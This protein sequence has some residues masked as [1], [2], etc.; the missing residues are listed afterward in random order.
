MNTP[1]PQIVSSIVNV[2]PMVLM[3]QPPQTSC[4]V[5]SAPA[6]SPVPCTQGSQSGTAVQA[7]EREWVRDKLGRL[8]TRSQIDH[9]FQHHRSEGIW[10]KQ[11]STH[12]KW[13]KPEDARMQ[14]VSHQNVLEKDCNIP[15]ALAAKDF[16]ELEGI[17]DVPGKNP[18][19]ALSSY[20]YDTMPWSTYMAL[21]ELYTYCVLGD[22]V[23]AV[24]NLELSD[25]SLGKL[26]CIRCWCKKYGLRSRLER[27]PL[28]QKFFL[29]MHK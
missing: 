18:M 16:T 7:A 12:G 15:D 6:M 3:K 17:T 21:A 1:S 13:Q 10:L 29:S 23:N 9:I 28:T 26:L 25:W 22:G 2:I 11:S 19:Q 24:V 5:S 14:V 20:L 4:H 27:D 8:R